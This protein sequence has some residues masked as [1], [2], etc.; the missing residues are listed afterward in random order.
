MATSYYP[1]FTDENLKAKL[2][3][4]ELIGRTHEG[5]ITSSRALR[6]VAKEEFEP[7][8]YLQRGR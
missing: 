2:D 3:M 5:G 8:L 4:M 6:T 7:G 1:H